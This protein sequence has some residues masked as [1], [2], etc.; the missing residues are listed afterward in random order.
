MEFGTSLAISASGISAQSARLRVIAE[1]LANANSTGQTPGS[2]PYRRQTITFQDAYNQKLNANLVTV[3]NIGTDSSSFPTKYDPS[4]P[5][6]NAQG[7]VK[8]P[9]VNS[10]VELMDM[11]QAERSYD[12]N[13]SVM[14][15]T[16]GMLTRTLGLI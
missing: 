9:N 15:A 2:N 13:L 16:R 12:A 10:F 1:N 7:Y 3:A 11:Q 6:A 14:N 4:N 5:A 8:L